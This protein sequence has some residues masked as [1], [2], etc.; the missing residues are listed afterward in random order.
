MYTAG[1]MDRPIQAGNS[2]QQQGA[3]ALLGLKYLRAN[4]GHI[5]NFTPSFLPENGATVLAFEDATADLLGQF[6]FRNDG[7]YTPGAMA[8]ISPCKRGIKYQSNK[9]NLLR[10]N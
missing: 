4:F 7:G 10:K 8:L 6:Y 2:L 9:I 3:S 1:P 5:F